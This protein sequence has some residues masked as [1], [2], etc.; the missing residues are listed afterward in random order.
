[1]SRVLTP[2]DNPVIESM[3]GWIKAQI[4]CDYNINEYD[5]IYDFIKNVSTAT[6]MNVL[7]TS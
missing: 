4:K 3:N 5:S 6:T 2:T 7:C 1:M